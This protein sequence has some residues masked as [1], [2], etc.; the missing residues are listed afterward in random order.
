VWPEIEPMFRLTFLG[1]TYSN[2]DQQA[3]NLQLPPLDHTDSGDTL[4]GNSFRAEI[5]DLLHNINPRLPSKIHIARERHADGGIHYHVYVEW[6]GVHT[7]VDS[8]AFDIRGIHPS[9]EQLRNPYAWQQYISKEE[10]PFEW[11]QV[12]DLDDDSGIEA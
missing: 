2:V 12:I 11:V 8:R 7:T 6:F 9:I 1:L 5:F 3:T 4:G 10:H